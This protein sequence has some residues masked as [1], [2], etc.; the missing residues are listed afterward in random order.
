[1]MIP[2]GAPRPMWAWCGARCP[3]CLGGF[4]ASPAA[5]ITTRA[6]RAATLSAVTGASLIPSLMLPLQQA[7]PA[8][9][10]NRS[11]PNAV[12]PWTAINV[13]AVKRA[14]LLAGLYSGRVREALIPSPVDQN[15]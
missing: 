10:L 12:G 5:I 15:R 2:V 3:T 1:M 13:S 4:M 8:S 14:D 7:N 6:A 9:G 11:D